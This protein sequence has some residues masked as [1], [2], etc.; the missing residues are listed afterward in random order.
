MVDQGKVESSVEFME[1]PSKISSG[2]FIELCAAYVFGG[3]VKLAP[4]VALTACKQPGR[5][6]STLQMKSNLAP[7]CSAFVVCVCTIV[8]GTIATVLVWELLRLCAHNDTQY[9]H[10]LVIDDL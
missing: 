2:N 4:L 5:S 3:I 7:F 6:S 9:N 8:A 10:V 1:V